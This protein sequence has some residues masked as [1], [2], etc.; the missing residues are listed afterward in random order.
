MPTYGYVM[1]VLVA[2]SWFF[3][4]RTKLRSIKHQVDSVL[5]D[6]LRFQNDDSLS[7]EQ[8]WALAAGADL[9]LRNAQFL[10]TLGT[11]LPNSREILAEWW[12][13]YTRENALEMLH[14]LANEGHRAAYRLVGTIMR[15]PEAKRRG[16]VERRAVEAGQD[17]LVETY[18]SMVAARE[19][20][21]DDELI[22]AGAALPS[23][24]SWDLGRLINICR[25]CYDVGMLSEEECW[26]HILPA[27]RALQREYGSWGELSTGYLM[28][29]AVWQSGNPGVE[30]G[31]LKSDRAMLLTDARSPWVQLAWETGEAARAMQA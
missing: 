11:G 23:I 17:D 8:R 13:I 31:L 6:P 10:D 30:Y 25:W 21:V 22:A 5:G 29:F 24:L 16:L 14:Y 26:Q 3:Q 4:N 7:R 20:L 15:E 18:E 9:A 27:A 19:L 12:G 1:L 28:G 2:I